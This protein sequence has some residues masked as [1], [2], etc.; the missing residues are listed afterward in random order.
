VIEKVHR[1]YPSFEPNRNFKWDMLNVVV[2]IIWQTSIVILPISIVTQQYPYIIG[3][4]VSI[5]ITSIILKFTWWNKLDEMSKETLPADFDEKV[6][7]GQ[8]STGLNT[9][10]AGD[11][12]SV[13][14]SK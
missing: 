6:K 3:T 5:T 2:G 10:V 9:A 12:A 7:T 14:Y 1:Y 11:E 13:A 4:V 8:V